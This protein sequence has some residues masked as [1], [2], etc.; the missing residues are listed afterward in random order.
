MTALAAW[1]AW[2]AKPRDC[3][4]APEDRAIAVCRRKQSRRR[5][6]Q[7]ATLG[8]LAC[9]PSDGASAARIERVIDVRTVG[10]ESSACVAPRVAPGGFVLCGD[11]RVS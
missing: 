9:G 11:V 3:R 4:P 1:T 6:R 2:L 10:E 8:S 5:M 7:S